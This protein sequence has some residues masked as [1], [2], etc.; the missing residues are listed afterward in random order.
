MAKFD[1]A[2]CGLDGFAKKDLLWHYRIVPNL[3]FCCLKFG[4]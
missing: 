1:C 2:S 4:V 3:F